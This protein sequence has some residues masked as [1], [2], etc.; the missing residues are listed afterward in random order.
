[1]TGRKLT[2]EQGAETGDEFFHDSTIFFVAAFV[3]KLTERD[4][5]V[6]D[7]ISLEP[8]PR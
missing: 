4:V 7:M 8:Q 1:M 6:R 2:K 5:F 3:N